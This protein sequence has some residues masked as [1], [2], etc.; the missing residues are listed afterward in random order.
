MSD[1]L[2]LAGRVALV[3]GAAQGIGKAIAEDLVR[4]GAKVVL[5][6]P[7]TGMDGSGADPKLTEAAAKA[8]GASAAAFA[9]SIASPSAA[10]AAVDMAV[11]RFGGLDIVVNNAAILRDAFVFKLEPRDWDA[12]IQ[13]NLTGA[14]L[15]TA[16][17][18]PL[19]R[20]NAKSNRGGAPYGW[21][22]IVNIG[23]T[24]GLYGNYGQASYASAKAGLFGLT[25]VT[26]LD[27]ARSGV[28]ANLVAPFAATRV[29]ESIKPANDGQAQYKARAMK[30]APR[31]VANLVAFLCGPQ[32]QKISGQVFGVRGREVFLFQQPRPMAK[33]VNAAGDWTPETLA[34]AVGREFA[35]NFTE[36]ATDLEAFNSEPIV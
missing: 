12:V 4:R 30:V 1:P 13:T 8:F 20:D 29:T 2:F 3:T 14:A 6:D 22:R 17:A 19:L 33:I 18:A 25:R 11:R 21:G 7:G 28:T 34:E 23:S 26:A 24:A 31:H 5:A 9:D 35:P 27:M 36:L 15:V 16:A 10:A 32:G